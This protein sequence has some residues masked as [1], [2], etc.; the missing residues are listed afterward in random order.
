MK[1]I[2]LLLTIFVL[3]C[4][5]VI[6]AVA[7]A[8]QGDND[9]SYDY[10]EPK[11]GTVV[12]EIEYVIDTEN[13]TVTVNGS[14]INDGAIVVP[15]TVKIDGVDYA[16]TAIEA[17]AFASSTATEI[18][19]PNTIETPVQLTGYTGYVFVQLKTPTATAVTGSNVYVKGD[20]DD[21]KAVDVGDV[22]RVLQTLAGGTV[23]GFPQL[24]CDVVASE[25][26]AVDVSDVIRILQWLAS[27]STIL[28]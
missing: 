21:D 11:E 13:T 2:G 27:S 17:D 7:T 20:Y 15:A 19:L 28:D 25:G 12:D 8:N 23:T 5:F 10:F 1:K 3:S 26:N 4:V 14:E 22:I 9:L 18:R 6:S 24:S 16:V